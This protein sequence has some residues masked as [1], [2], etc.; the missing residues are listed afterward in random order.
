MTFIVAKF[1]HSIDPF[2]IMRS[3]GV[4][5]QFIEFEELEGIYILPVSLFVCRRALN[6]PTYN[7][8]VQISI[9]FW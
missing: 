1:F 3:F 6:S 7:Y 8:L 5:Y 9:L 2:K 4:I